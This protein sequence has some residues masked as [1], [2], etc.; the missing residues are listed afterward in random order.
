MK[1]YAGLAAWILVS[2]SAGFFG[3]RFSPG[4]WYALLEKPSWNP[5]GWVFGPV[6][7]ILYILMGVAVWLVWKSRGFS[8]AV[9]LFLAQLA[10][11]ALWSY[12]FFGINRPGL[13]FLE[14]LVL[15]VLIL[16]TML[17]FRRV[18]TTAGALMVPYLLWVSFASVLNYAL[19]RLNA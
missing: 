10:L 9:Y 17:A 18:S 15:W 5:P 16:A 19:W 7:T 4:E 13:A 12:L 14:I 11:N 1:V 3:S 8:G 6:W 2:L